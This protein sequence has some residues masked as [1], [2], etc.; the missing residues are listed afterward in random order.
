[1]KAFD[2]QSDTKRSSAAPSRGGGGGGGRGGVLSSWSKNTG[3]C[4]SRD[5]LQDKT[6][7]TCGGRDLFKLCSFK[8]RTFRE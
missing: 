5:S 3:R 6:I 2:F 8:S 1:M 4:G 7:G